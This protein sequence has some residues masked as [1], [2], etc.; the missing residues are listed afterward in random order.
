MKSRA[1]TVIPRRDIRTVHEIEV[2]VT[3]AVA[4]AAMGAVAGPP[5]A[6][7]G[8]VIGGVVGVLAGASLESE[9]EDAAIHEAALDE[10]IGVNGGDLGAACLEH[11]D[12]TRGVASSA[13]SGAG[14][15][16]STPA[17]GPMQSVD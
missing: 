2:G 3:G 13:S 1:K 6:V 11:P 8:A 15:R 12:A 7:A 10:E 4:G 14:G 17:E 16:V 5:G 9:S